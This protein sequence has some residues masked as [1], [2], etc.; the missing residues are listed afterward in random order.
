M[1]DRRFRLRTAVQQLQL[2]RVMRAGARRNAGGCLACAEKK[3]ARALDG[4]DFV[5]IDEKRQHLLYLESGADC[6]QGVITVS[7]SLL[8]A[9]PHV[10]E[11]A[12]C[13]PRRAARALAVVAV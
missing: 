1:D 10:Q 11:R 9:H 12:S 8:R 6:D 5:G 7:Q 2:L 13:L 4:A 3:K